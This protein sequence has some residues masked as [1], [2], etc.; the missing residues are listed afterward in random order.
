MALKVVKVLNNDGRS[1]EVDIKFSNGEIRRH[2]MTS[3]ALEVQLLSEEL[4]DKYGVSDDF[5][6]KFIDAV[7]MEVHRDYD[8]EEHD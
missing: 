1:A 6:D 2:Y 3:E 4:R 7:H 5:I 8:D